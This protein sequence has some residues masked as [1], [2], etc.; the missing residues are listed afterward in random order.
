MS[1]GK[2]KGRKKK[3]FKDGRQIIKQCIAEAKAQ[4][5]MQKLEDLH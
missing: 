2:Q 3:G 1:G 4:Y 5:E